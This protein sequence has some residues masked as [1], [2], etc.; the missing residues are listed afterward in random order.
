[1]HTFVCFSTHTHIYIYIIYIFAVKLGSGPILRVLKF[2]FW[3]NLEARFWTKMILTDFYSG[4][5]AFLC[6]NLFL[7]ELAT[8]YRPTFFKITFLGTCEEWFSK[9]QFRWENKYVFETT[10]HYN[11]RGFKRFWGIFCAP[12]DTNLPKMLRT[13]KKLIKL[14]NFCQTYAHMMLVQNCLCWNANFLECFLEFWGGG[15]GLKIFCKFTKHFL[16]TS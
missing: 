7:F 5:R 6:K 10:K 8:C 11:D 4:F 15:G 12:Q 2:R 16:L 1:M 13:D 3:G 14:A 9:N